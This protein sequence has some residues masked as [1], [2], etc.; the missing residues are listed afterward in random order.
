MGN[1]LFWGYQDQFSTI[2][3]HNLDYWTP[4]RTNAYYPR[5]YSNGSGNTGTSRNTQT[6]Y[7]QNG[8]YLRVKNVTLAYNVPKHILGKA[9]ADALRIFASGENLFLFDHLP[10]G[11]ESDAVV[12][13]DGG[14]YPSLKKY[15]V[16]L[17]LSF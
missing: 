2:Y 15:S 9:K 4:E 10:N 5:M 8:A 13:T 6:G 11:M 17:N 1:R 3:K 12:I 7:L 16:G 14:I